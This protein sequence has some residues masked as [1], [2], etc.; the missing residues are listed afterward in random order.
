MNQPPA[1]DAGPDAAVVLPA[2]AS[3]DG[4]VTDDGLPDPPAN[5]TTAWSKTSGPGT[6]TF[7][8]ATAVDT[9]ASVSGTRV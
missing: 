7:A 4:S 9:A 1:V 3:L 2:S 5:V 6:V 8:D